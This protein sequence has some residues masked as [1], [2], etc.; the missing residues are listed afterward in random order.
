MKK[1]LDII[2]IIAALIP[3]IKALIRE[4]EEMLPESG[5]GGEK[6][7]L[8]REMLEAVFDTLDDIPVAFA[9]IWPALE[10]LIAKFVAVFNA[11]GEFRKA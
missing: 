3:A 4:V 8:V 10:R 7:A 2:R 6:L 1:L 5:R 9:E 11:V